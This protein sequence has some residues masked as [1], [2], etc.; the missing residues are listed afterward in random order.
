M[1]SGFADGSNWLAHLRH[2]LLRDA[3]GAGRGLE[4]NHAAGRHDPDAPLAAGGDLDAGFCKHALHIGEYIYLGHVG[5]EQAGWSRHGAVF[6][7]PYIWRG[8]VNH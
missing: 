6:L 2:E 4:H 1:F 8:R 3:A 5:F 7:I